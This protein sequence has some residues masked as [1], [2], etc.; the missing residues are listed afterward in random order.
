MRA[1]DAAHFGIGMRHAGY[2]LYV[3][4]PSGSGKHTLIRQLLDQRVADE[5]KPADWCYVHNFTQPHKPRVIKLPTGL[6]TRLHADMQHLVADRQAAIPA[7]FEGE[8]YRHR[9][10]KIDEEYSERQTG[11]FTDVGEEAGKHN[12]VLLRTPNGFSF[13]PAKDGEVMSPDDYE[14]LPAEER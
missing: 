1:I 7:V 12:I 11:A 10:S 5:A 14:K 6:G 13:A 8:E 4:G 3:M 9:L 2:N